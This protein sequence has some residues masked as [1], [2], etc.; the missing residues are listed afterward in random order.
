LAS[1]TPGSTERN[2]AGPYILEL[3]SKLGSTPVRIQKDGSWL[4]FSLQGASAT[5]SV[6]GATDTFSEARP[7]V[8]VIYTAQ[9]DG[10]KEITRLQSASAPSS[11]TYTLAT[12]PD[13]TPQQTKDGGIEFLDG[14]GQTRFTMAAPA[15]Q[16]ASGAAGPASMSFQATPTAST[17]T[18]SVDASWL[19]DPARAFPVTIDPTVTLGPTQ[20]CYIQSN[21]LNTRLCGTSE[22]VGGGSTIERSL[23]QF[24]LSSVSPH[25]TVANAQLGL[26]LNTASSAAASIALHQVTTPWS[27][28]TWSYATSFTVPWQTPGGD[29]APTPAYTNPAIGPA[30]GTYNWYPTQLVQAWVNGSTANNGLLL[31]QTNEAAANLF[32]FDSPV[33]TVTYHHWLGMQPYQP[34]YSRGLTDRMSV[35]VDLADGNLLVS[36]QDLQIA[37]TGIGLSIGRYY[38]SQATGTINVGAQWELG[39]GAGIKLNQFAD[40]SVD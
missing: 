6:S 26:N 16:D 20:R 25:S 18:V 38:N 12:S 17:I 19:K 30:A 4:S 35:S 28:P 9:N 34:F 7:G 15:V 37:G 11:F 3:P 22:K 24:D 8:E 23:Y 36:N 39:T 29:F 27:L 31:K 14:S 40:G 33:L 21:F 5:G 1:T 13:I 32:A 2:Q 10:V